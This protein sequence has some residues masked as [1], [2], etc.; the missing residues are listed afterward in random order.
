MLRQGKQNNGFQLDNISLL[1]ESNPGPYIHKST[2]RRQP[3]K[4]MP[5]NVMTRG[6]RTPR[7]LIALVQS[8][9]CC[10]CEL[11]E[12]WS[13]R[14]R[15]LKK[16]TCVGNLAHEGAARNGFAVELDVDGVRLG[17]LGSE[18]HEAAASAENLKSNQIDYL[19]PQGWP[20]KRTKGAKWNEMMA[21]GSTNVAFNW[22]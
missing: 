10:C 1:H 15:E 14:E 8:S 11:Q 21:S 18:V 20:L 13:E 5:H 22:S 6:N 4:V 12:T 17:L 7:N 9:W 3:G 16:L 2:Q 19:I